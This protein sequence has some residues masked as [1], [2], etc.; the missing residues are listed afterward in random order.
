MKKLLAVALAALSLGVFAQD[1]EVPPLPTPPKPMKE[2][3]KEERDAF[4]KERKEALDKLTPEQREAHKRKIRENVERSTGGMV[5]N[6]ANQRG[7]VVFANAQK[8]LSTEALAEPIQKVAGHMKI[9]MDVISIDAVPAAKDLPAWL[10][11]EKINAVV[12]VVEKD[13]C[14]ALLVAPEERWA[15]VN[16]AALV[17]PNME[18]GRHLDRAR[19]EMLRAFAYLCGGF[20]SQYQ[21]VLTHAV[22]NVRQ[23]DFA[24]NADLPID[25]INRILNHLQGLGVTPYVETTYRNACRQGWAPPPANDIQKAVWERVNAEKEKGP[26]NAMKIT[27]DPANAKKDG[28]GAKAEPAAAN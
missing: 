15:Q 7:R 6:T 4:L 20:T 5:R 26:Q 14:G 3:T 18:E 16:V 13:D 23:L 8:T 9:A 22:T 11:A 21:D 2:M 10:K 28:A 19:K 1:V 24:R 27:L 12:F 17:T 25:V